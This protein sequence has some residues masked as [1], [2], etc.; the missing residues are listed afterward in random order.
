[1]P[2]A[3]QFEVGIRTAVRGLVY[4][5][6]GFVSRAQLLKRGIKRQ[7]RGPSRD[8]SLLEKLVL[9]LPLPSSSRGDYGGQVL[10]LDRSR[11]GCG[12]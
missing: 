6:C 4:Y 8:A 5:L 10:G 3:G 9:T 7:E 11:M 1:M 2:G 12:N